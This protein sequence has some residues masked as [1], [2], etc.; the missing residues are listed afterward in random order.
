MSFDERLGW[1]I[2]GCLIGFALGYIVRYLQE[3]KEELGVVEEAVRHRKDEDG[4]LRHP[5]ALDITLLFVVLLTVWASFASQKASNEVQESQETVERSTA[6]NE[7]FLSKTMVALNERTAYTKAQ[8]DA[9]VELQRSQAEFLNI[10]LA[11]PPVPEE[12]RKRAL[13]RYFDALTEFVTVNG[14][15]EMKADRYPFP[16]VEELRDCLDS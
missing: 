6:C 7:V 10:I 15:A 1:L 5:V 11:E 3:I 14:K 8:V 4:L 13:K 12:A 16:T 9:N 2:L